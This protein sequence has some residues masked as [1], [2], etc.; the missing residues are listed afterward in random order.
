MKFDICLEMVHTDLPYDKRIQKIAEAGFGCV[1]FWFHDST[2][3]GT[4]CASDLPKDAKTLKQVCGQCGVT[5]NNMVVNS[6][7]GAVGGII[8]DSRELNK[9]IDRLHEVISFSKEAGIL[10][11]IICTGNVVEGLSRAQMRTN[12]LK[13]Y[14]EAARIAEQENYTLFV[15]TLNSHVDHPGYY[16]DNWNEGVEIIKEINSPHLKLLYDIYH[17]QIM[18]GNVIA[19]IQR[20]IDVIGHFHSAGVPGRHDLNNGELDYRQIIDRIEKTGY[21]GSF[22]LEYSPIGDNDASLKSMSKYLA[23]MQV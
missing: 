6:P 14:S 10:K 15:E 20:D 3:D 18:H 7:D 16:L 4:T 11:A 9:Y 19:T 17:M 2:F 23:G 5:I 8:V 21:T 22:G 13:A 12:L 1:E